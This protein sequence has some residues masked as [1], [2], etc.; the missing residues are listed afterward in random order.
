MSKRINNRANI[1]VCAACIAAMLAI[2]EVVGVILFI[3]V[4]I[5]LVGAHGQIKR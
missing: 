5:F 4:G 2:G 1:V 3:I